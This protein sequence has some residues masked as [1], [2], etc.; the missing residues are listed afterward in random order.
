MTSGIGRARARLVSLL[1]SH[2]DLADVRRDPRRALLADLTA[3]IVA[4]PL[5]LG[6]GVSSSPP[7]WERKRAWRRP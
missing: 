1:P 4:L 6:F 2:T 3:A 5:P 7:D